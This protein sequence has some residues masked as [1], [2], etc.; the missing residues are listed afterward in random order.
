MMK[1][2]AYKLDSIWLTQKFES[3][4]HDEYTWADRLQIPL[5]FLLGKE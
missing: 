4:I 1:E 2:R 5:E 3:A